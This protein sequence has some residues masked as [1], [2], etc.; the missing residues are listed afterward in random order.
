MN[1]DS[2]RHE[3][4]CSSFPCREA[5]TQLGQRSQSACRPIRPCPLLTSQPEVC[6][7]WAKSMAKEEIPAKAE[8]QAAA[9]EGEKDKAAQ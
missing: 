4:N 2:Y 7:I 9:P 6:T 8:P 5:E 1:Q 3:L